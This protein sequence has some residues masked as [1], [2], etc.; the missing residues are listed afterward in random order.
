MGSDLDIDPDAFESET[1]MHEVEVSDFY[2]GK[3]LVTQDF[4]NTVMGTNPSCFYGPKRPVEW[5]S[6]KETQEFIK[7]LS[8]SNGTQFRLPSEAEWEYAARGGNYNLGCTYAGSNRL[9]DVGWYDHNCHKE[10]KIIG[11][12]LPN[13]LGL[14]D[15][16]GNVSEWCEDNWH[17]NY[18][19]APSDGSVW[20]ND[21]IETSRVFRGGGHVFS[22]QHSRPAYRG[23]CDMSIG[24]HNLGFRLALSR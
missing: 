14:Y 1:P 21:N 2:I 17:N 20:I 13:E 19:G 8:L 5:V 11:R 24:Y 18:Q 15:M 3:Y 4:W 22:S 7:K 9:R 12:K 10:T 16:S 23:S 6:W